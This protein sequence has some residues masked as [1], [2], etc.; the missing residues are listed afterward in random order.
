MVREPRAACAAVW[1]VSEACD[2]L[3]PA[4]H[5]MY[6]PSVQCVRPCQAE[7]CR[8]TGIQHLSMKARGIIATGLDWC[9]KD[10]GVKGLRPGDLADGVIDLAL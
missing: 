4:Y 1:V 10:S 6:H 2:R 9:T 3:D 5:T 8:D 7:N